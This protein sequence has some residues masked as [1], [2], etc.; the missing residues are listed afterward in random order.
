[1]LERQLAIQSYNVNGFNLVNLVKSNAWKL[2]GVTDKGIVQM[3]P[4]SVLL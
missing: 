4:I 3:E 2:P 1:M